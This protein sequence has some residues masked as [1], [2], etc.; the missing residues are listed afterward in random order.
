MVEDDLTEEQREEGD[1]LLET[2]DDVPDLWILPHDLP[3]DGPEALLGVLSALAGRSRRLLGQKLVP[4][5]RGGGWSPGAPVSA[6]SGPGVAV[7]GLQVD[8][9]LWKLAR[10]PGVRPILNLRGGRRVMVPLLKKLVIV[11][12]YL[13]E[14]G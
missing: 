13:S 5:G 1:V 4:L 2:V 12:S 3:V 14:K 10:S 9:D 8:L 7:P 11:L 6:N